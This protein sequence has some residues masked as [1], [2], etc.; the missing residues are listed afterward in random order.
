MVILIVIQIGEKLRNYE[1]RWKNEHSHSKAQ[2]KSFI[3]EWQDKISAFH[4]NRWLQ[5]SRIA[6]LDHRCWVHTYAY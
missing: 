3:N 1:G 6:I 2:N 5:S 4:D